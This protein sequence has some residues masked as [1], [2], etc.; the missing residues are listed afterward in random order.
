MF[1]Q[2]MT[3]VPDRES[4]L[5]NTLDEYKNDYDYV[6]I[7][8]PP[9]VSLLTF[10]AL[11]AA[12]NVIVPVETGYFALHGLSKQ[13]ETLS[14]LSMRTNKDVNVK[15]LATM[16]DIRTKM[17][18]EI[19]AD[20]RSHFG[21][22]MFET[23]VTFNTKIKEASSFGQPIGEYDPASKGHKDFRSLATEVLSVQVKQQRHEFVNSLSEQLDSISLTANELLEASK[24]QIE[25]EVVVKEEPK[26][27]AK[28]EPM[29]E[30]KPEIAIQS[31]GDKIEINFNETEFVS[32]E[33]QAWKELEEE[34]ISYQGHEEQELEKVEQV[35]AEEPQQTMEEKLSDYY[36]VD[37]VHDAV[38]FVTL[39]PRAESVQIAGDFNNWQPEQT[40][41]QRVGESG[42]WQT[43]L[44]LPAGKYRYR[45]VVDGHWQQDP[46]NEQTE[47]NPFGELNSVFDV[48]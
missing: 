22:K 25:P 29:V 28:P 8:C 4:C 17:A 1:L 24:K 5:K 47:M 38:V 3:G 15:I 14:V 23:I 18:R 40:A 10:N 7:D 9:A 39:Y 21:D 45:F 26:V 42:V 32:S 2:Q 30:A 20:L 34:V 41:M 44:D 33:D 31:E 6:V 16:Y 12:N 13:L 19:L 11:R 37:Q 46:Y 35:A 43:K 36:G 27:E 48:K